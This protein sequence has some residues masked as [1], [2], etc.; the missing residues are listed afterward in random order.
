MTIISTKTSAPSNDEIQIPKSFLMR[1]T[2]REWDVMLHLSKGMTTPEIAAQIYIE[3]KSVENY[4]T[5]IA[6]KLELKGRNKLVW[7]S[8]KNQE[9]LENWY[10]VSKMEL[11][12]FTPRRSVVTQITGIVLF[13]KNIKL[14]DYQRDPAE[15]R[16]QDPQIKSLLLYQLSYGVGNIFI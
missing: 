8:W 14:F 16:T 7:F 1:L 12:D 11:W 15:A 4:R 3:P 13:K 5:R 10:K 2:K 9:F 6:N